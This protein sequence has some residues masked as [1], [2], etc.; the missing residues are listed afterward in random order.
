[1]NG[2]ADVAIVGLGA[3]GSAAAWQ[4][5]AL[6]GLPDWQRVTAPPK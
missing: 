5:A 6:R 2:R 3:M 4:L 1:M